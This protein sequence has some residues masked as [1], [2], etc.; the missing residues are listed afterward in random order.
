[1]PVI[2]LNGRGLCIPPVPFPKG[3]EQ[4]LP[5]ILRIHLTDKAIAFRY[6]F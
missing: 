1:M 6:S 3:R 5:D 2:T 4:D